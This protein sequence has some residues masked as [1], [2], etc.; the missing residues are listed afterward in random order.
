MNIKPVVL[1]AALALLLPVFHGVAL[2]QDD[3]RYQLEKTADG[4]IR[5]DKATGDMSICREQTGQLVCRAA[6]DDRKALSDEIGRLDER[7]AMIETKLSAMEKSRLSAD[8]GMPTD[9]E[10][11]KTMGYMERFFRRFMGVVKD[12]N[13]NENGPQKT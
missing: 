8:N 5:L 1:F 10:F 12:L 4:Y 7:L 3:A 9:E 2:A 13:E 6:A 11:E